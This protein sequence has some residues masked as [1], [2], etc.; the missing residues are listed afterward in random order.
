MI[1]ELNKDEIEALLHKSLIG[2]IGCH[3]NGMTYIVPISYAYD[4]DCVYAHTY[5]G[6]KMKLMRQNP[7]VCFE[8]DDTKDTSNWQSVIAWGTFEELHNPDERTK[9]LRILND[10]VLP[11][12]SSSTT[13]L[14]RNW[15]FSTYSSDDV[16]GILF[17]IRLKEKTGRFERTGQTPRFNY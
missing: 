1:A 11:L 9:A 16:A 8:V 10:R 4:S 6:M 15:P 3:A 7:A 13:H 5:E 14:G 17:R 2:R 12:Q